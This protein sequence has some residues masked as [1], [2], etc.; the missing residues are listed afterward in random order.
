MMDPWQEVGGGCGKVRWLDG[1]S[2]PKFTAENLGK[3]TSNFKK[4]KSKRILIA[5]KPGRL[6]TFTSK[7]PPLTPPI[8]KESRGMGSRETASI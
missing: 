1:N 5:P 8:G 3:P 6:S 7:P 4:K 2:D